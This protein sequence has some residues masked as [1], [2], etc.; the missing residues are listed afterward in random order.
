VRALAS[1][2]QKSEIRNQ[3]SFSLASLRPYIDWTPFFQTW[4]LKGKYPRIFD[5][6]TVG[7]EARRLFDDAN[8]LLDR[9]LA[10]NLLEARGAY[11]FW[12][13]NSTGKDIVVCTDDTRTGERVR[14][15]ALRQ[16]WRR[17]GQ[18][19]FYSLADFVAPAPF[20][21]FIGAFAV[22]ITGADELARKFDAEHDDYNSITTKALADRLAEAFAEYLHA[23][24]RR[25]WAY[26]ADENLSHED[27]IAECYRGIRPAPGYPAQPDHTEKRTI[28]KLLNATANIGVTLTDS[29]AMH[30]AASVCGLY[31]SHP[32]AKYFAVDRITR[33]QVEDYARRKGMSVAEV[34][35]WLAGNLGYE[36]N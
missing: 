8:H 9:I 27:L 18:E 29:L 6:P 4:E 14:L 11:G 36:P 10:E 3:K 1:G 23:Q 26:G 30:P 16:Q 17:K 13:A 5:D 32:K 28:F 22:S 35:R 21:D 20:K 19:V 15:H 12:P 25:D 34:E 24:A 2:N 7:P 33:D 31:F